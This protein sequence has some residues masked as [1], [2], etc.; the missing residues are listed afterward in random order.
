MPE[1]KEE[2]DEGPGDVADTPPAS[3]GYERPSLNPED[4]PGMNQQEI[5]SNPATPAAADM[6]GFDGDAKAESK[7]GGLSAEEQKAKEEDEFEVRTPDSAS[8]NLLFLLAL[9]SPDIITPRHTPS[10]A[11][12]SLL[13]STPFR[14]RSGGISSIRR[15]WTFL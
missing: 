12:R 15:Q 6:D 9:R 4:I 10:P 11:G 5:K 3:R 8:D 14:S 2:K 7:V 13:V 1:G